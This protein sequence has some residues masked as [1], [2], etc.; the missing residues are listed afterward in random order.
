[1]SM[2]DGPAALDVGVENSHVYM[3][4]GKKDQRAGAGVLRRNRR[5]ALFAPALRRD[6]SSPSVR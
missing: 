3:Y 1:M 4:V 5:T 2:E 6:D